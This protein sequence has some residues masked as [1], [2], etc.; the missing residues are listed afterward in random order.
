[1]NKKDLVRVVA[2]KTDN[3]L[4]ITADIITATFDA[5]VEACAKGEKVQIV[6]FGSFESKQRAAKVSRNPKTGEVVNV[7][8]FKSPAFKAG[9]GFKDKVNI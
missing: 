5:I 7:P 8:P 4:G 6:D 3:Q 9:K 1:M 2:S